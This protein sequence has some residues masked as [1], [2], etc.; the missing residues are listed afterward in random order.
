[1][2]FSPDCCDWRLTIKW[3]IH[4]SCSGVNGGGAASASW[5]SPLGAPVLVPARSVL[6]AMSDS[7]RRAPN[8]PA[9]PIRDERAPNCR[10]AYPLRDESSC[11]TYCACVLQPCVRLGCARLRRCPRLSERTAGCPA[12]I[13]QLV[14]WLQL[15]L[16]AR[17]VHHAYQDHAF[18]CPLPCLQCSP[19]A[20]VN[21]V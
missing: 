11:L 3:S 10:P 19:I 20:F 14:S 2:S 13:M 7:Q 21:L 9:Y 15:S 8:W 5:G 18:R 4:V 16:G 6:S 17:L 1:M 12:P